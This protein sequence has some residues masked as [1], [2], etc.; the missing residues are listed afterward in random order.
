MSSKSVVRSVLQ[1]AAATA[2]VYALK[3]VLKRADE[4]LENNGVAQGKRVVILGG[5]FAG[6]AVAQELARLLPDQ[7]NGE[8]LLIDEDNYLLFTPMLTEAAGGAIEAAHIVSPL[9]SLE[10]RVRFVQGR[11]VSLDLSKRE[12]EVRMGPDAQGELSERFSGDHLVLALGSVTNTHGTPG[13]EEYGLGMK[14]LA[15]A[16][17]V[18]QQVST[19][20]ERASAE[21]DEARRKE[22]LTFVVAGGGYTGVETMAAIN[23]FL[24][25]SAR[26]MPGLRAEQIHAILVCP[27][28]RLLPELSEELASYA[29]EQLKQH[30]VEIRLDAS[31]SGVAENAVELKNGERIAARTLVWAAGVTPNPLIASLPAAKGKH[32][33]LVVDGSC[34]VKDF[35]GVWALGDCAEIP[36][37]D[38][39]GTYATTAQNATREGKLVAQNIVATLH[40]EAPQPFRF[41][42]LGELALVGRHTG[43]A[44][45]FGFNFSGVLAWAMWRAVYLA[46]MP[47]LAQRGRVLSDWVLDA[48]FGHVPVPLSAGEHAQ[49][50]HVPA[51]SPAQG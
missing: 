2:S 27:E 23:D 11:A 44:R 34:Q 41:T 9:R 46:K 25:E 40:G 1:V 39:K 6:A 3:T 12:V 50:A 15:D 43:V 48:L 30:G 49:T 22:L 5:G 45:V 4:R 51:P 32:H 47:N 28:S 13:V 14:T 42:P 17:K 29:T 33:G 10:P 26:S 16:R 38:G 18:F 35:A 36:Q 24:R 7:S 37:P 31:V 21:P 20:L 19:C 8:I